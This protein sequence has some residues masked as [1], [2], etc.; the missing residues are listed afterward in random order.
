MQNPSGVRTHASEA[1]FDRVLQTAWN[2]PGAC[3]HPV[4]AIVHLD[5]LFGHQHGFEHL[6][7]EER[8]ALRQAVEGIEHSR[9]QGS[10]PRQDGSQHGPGMS[11]GQRHQGDVLSQVFAVELR[12]KGAQRLTHFLPAIGQKQEQ[13]GCDCLACQ[14]EE[15]LK[16]A[17]VAPMEILHDQQHRSGARGSRED[18]SQGREEAALLLF[19][20]QRRQGRQARQFGE[21]LDLLRKQGKEHTRGGFQRRR[22]LCGREGCQERTHEVKQGSIRAGPIGWEALSTEKLERK[23][24]SRSLQFGHQ[25]RFANA[26]FP[27]EQDNTSL[28][29][30]G[31]FE[32]FL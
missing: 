28:P 25:P 11:P 10:R 27:G 8:I 18:I 20:V 17:L 6:F 2:A 19:G 5:Q 29:T 32:A 14:E 26:S 23:S 13:P 1:Q 7:Q 3:S 16:G 12:Q 9:R 24:F 22:H 31:G 15:K 4:P 30:H 21:M